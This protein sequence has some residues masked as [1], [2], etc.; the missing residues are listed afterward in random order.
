MMLTEKKHLRTLLRNKRNALTRAQIH[1]HSHSAMTQFA[2]SPLFLQNEHFACYLAANHEIE[3]QLFIEHVFQH[4]KSCY[5]PKL[6]KDHM[7]FVYYQLGDP[8]VPNQFNILEPKLTHKNH[9]EAK[10]MD[11]ILT[12]LVGF[13]SQGH[14]LGMGGGFY[15][16]T[17][18]NL[19]GD[20]RPTI[21]G[22]AFECQRVD[23]IPTDEW[24]IPLDVVLTENGFEFFSV[25]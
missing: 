18:E 10:D 24:D 1:A 13:D 4:K 23:T 7:V 20:S 19:K 22:L 11:V 21:I 9:R 16:R 2:H 12:P 17:L 25:G 6:E 3:T 8:L 5:L 14:R 15:D